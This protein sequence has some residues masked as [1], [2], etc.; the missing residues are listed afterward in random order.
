MSASIYWL[1]SYMEQDFKALFAVSDNPEVLVKRNTIHRYL[2]I[3][4]ESE[5]FLVSKC[6]CEGMKISPM[7]WT[8]PFCV[9]LSHTQC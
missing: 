4:V 2:A 1:S 8:E 6:P 7:K 3:P 9:N 5:D